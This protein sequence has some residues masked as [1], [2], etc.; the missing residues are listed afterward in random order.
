[1]RKIFLTTI[2]IVATFGAG[3]RMANSAVSNV[4]PVVKSHHARMDAALNA[5]TD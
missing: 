5:A 3:L 4:E 2:I 1:M